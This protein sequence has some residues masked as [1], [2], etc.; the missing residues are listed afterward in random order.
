MGLL[1][2]PGLSKSAADAAYAPAIRAGSAIT[3]D[4]SL[5][6]ADATKTLE[7]RLT[8]DATVKVP[9]H[10]ATAFPNGAEIGVV[11][12]GTGRVRIE[13]T[14]RNR[15]TNPTCGV[16]TSGWAA[17]TNTTVARNA[18]AGLGGGPAARGTS[19]AAGSFGI[20]GEKLSL[21]AAGLA[22][23]D[24]I[25][26]RGHAGL[27][28][29][30]TVCGLALRFYTGASTSEVGRS[31]I[32]G[33]G[34]RTVTNQV[35]PA[36]VDAIMLVFYAT[37]TAAGDTLDISQAQVVKGATQ[38]AEYC[39]G[40]QP[41]CFWTG[42]AHA[43]ASM[44]PLLVG[45]TLVPKLG[46]VTLRHLG[47]GVWTL[48]PLGVP[49]GVMKTTDS[50]Y[51]DR[52]N[53]QA[54]MM[55]PSGNTNR[56]GTA[57]VSGRA[58]LGRF[59]PSRKMQITRIVFRVSAASATD[60]PVDVGIYSAA[61]VKLVSSGAVSGLL[62]TAGT[63]AV[64]VTATALEPGVVYYSAL[65]ATSTAGV[66]LS[67]VAGDVY[68]TAMPLL[69]GAVKDASYPLPATISAPGSSDFAVSLWVRES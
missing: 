11:S 3:A 49:D 62:N 28:A 2:P 50:L 36:G 25:S 45:E 15:L 19:V 51:V 59:V 18:T 4:T 7:S 60:D 58:Y 16:S 29:G 40:D 5:A 13:P 44:G 31:D 63:K 52:D 46:R 14:K 26:V 53:G 69:E 42:T 32:A 37:A 21:A 65:A 33:S 41:G 64:V 43:S 39:D 55:T 24:V 30:T 66:H 20:F 61:G 23:G 56:T 22:P 35:I 1:D 57:L 12:A 27:S 6:L 48:A 68:G 17:R 38:P 34:P 9:T 67:G 47:S 10:T 8:T 54:G